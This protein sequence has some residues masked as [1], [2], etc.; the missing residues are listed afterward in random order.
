[1][2]ATNT[3]KQSKSIETK[4]ELNISSGRSKSRNNLDYDLNHDKLEESDDMH[5]KVQTNLLTKLSFF[6]T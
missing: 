4:S 1:M 5:P 3:Q 2:R 6:S